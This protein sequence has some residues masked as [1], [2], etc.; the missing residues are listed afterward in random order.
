[1]GSKVKL[2]VWNKD[3]KRLDGSLQPVV[4]EKASHTLV[5]QAGALFMQIEHRHGRTVIPLPSLSQF[6]EQTDD[7]KAH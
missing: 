7:A 3:M 6:Q 5:E 2:I 4:Y 1:M